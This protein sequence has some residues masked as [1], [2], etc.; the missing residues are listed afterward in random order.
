MRMRDNFEQPPPG[1]LGLRPD[2][3]VTI[4][5]RHLPHWRQAGATYFVTFRLAD[6]LARER[7]E[8]LRAERERWIAAH[9][10][11][12]PADWEAF[13][14]QDFARLE[15]GLD[16]GY[17]SRIL[18]NADA[19]DALARAMGFFEGER[20]RLG[21]WGIMPTH[22]HAVVT[23]LAVADV[24]RDSYPVSGVGRD[25][26]PVL[27]GAEPKGRRDGSPVPR[28]ESVQTAP[29][30]Y[31]LEDIIGSWKRRSAREIHDRCGG[32]GALW[33]EEVFDRIVRDTPELR[34]T[35]AY[36]EKNPA[37]AGVSS[38]FWMRRD[39]EDWFRGEV[40]RDSYPVSGISGLGRDRNPVLQGAEPMGRRD[41][42]PVPQLRQAVS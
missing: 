15:E 34:R 14:R 24:G 10:E 16:A 8:E 37:N 2:L 1:F 29:A 17:G 23:P 6:S 12:T 7:V 25:G 36:I 35:V 9:S 19:R 13:Q 26:N 5:R 31:R 32:H 27:R 4:Y 22:V 11:P 41:G 28:R 38:P 42:N 40:G 20:Y 3:P 18:A 30:C 21:A 33:Q 39:W